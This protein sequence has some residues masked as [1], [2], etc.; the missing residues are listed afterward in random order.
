MQS[1]NPPRNSRRNAIKVLIAAGAAAI[2][3]PYI[4]TSRKSAPS[5]KMTTESADQIVIRTSGGK[6]H[7]AYTEILFVS[8]RDYSKN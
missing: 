6:S 4:I 1:K 3:I 7:Y 2:A 8:L 5:R